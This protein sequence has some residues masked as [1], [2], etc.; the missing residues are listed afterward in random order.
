MPREKKTLRGPW[1]Y[2]LC[3]ECPIIPEHY[4]NRLLDV[5][6]EGGNDD[7]GD[8]STPTSCIRATLIP[9]RWIVS[10]FPAAC[11]ILDAILVE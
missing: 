10:N 9:A 5:L 3:L 2:M 8:D 11:G 7:L 1:T 6:Y 4:Q